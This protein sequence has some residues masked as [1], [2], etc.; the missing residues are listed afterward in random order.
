MGFLVE[1]EPPFR[2]LRAFEEVSSDDV[3]EPDWLGHSDEGV[4]AFAFDSKLLAYLARL[5]SVRMCTM[6]ERNQIH[7]TLQ[8]CSRMA[9]S[10][11]RSS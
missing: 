5:V 4:T 9:R 8:L 6:A 3:F 2:I 10:E 7:L 11:S 1:G